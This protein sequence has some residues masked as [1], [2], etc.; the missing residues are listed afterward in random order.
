MKKN[1]TYQDTQILEA[2]IACGGNLRKARLML[3]M[4]VHIYKRVESSPI[5]KEKINNY[6]AQQAEDTIEQAQELKQVLFEKAKSG[7]TKALKLYLDT[8]EN[9][10]KINSLSELN[11]VIDGKQISTAKTEVIVGFKTVAAKEKDADEKCP[12]GTPLYELDE[13]D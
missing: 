8:Y 2:I 7:D 12:D 11:N 3:G 10:F 13:S 5:L 9:F 1:N 6:F 4:S